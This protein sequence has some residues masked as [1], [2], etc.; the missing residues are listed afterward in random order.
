MNIKV[1]G[2]VFR[3][4]MRSLCEM[5]NKYTTVSKPLQKTRLT[6]ELKSHRYKKSH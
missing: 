5:H 6:G 2:G 1:E 3:H 4:C